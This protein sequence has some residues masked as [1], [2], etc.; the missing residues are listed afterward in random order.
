MTPPRAATWAMSERRR[1]PMACAVMAKAFHQQL[2]PE[3]EIDRVRHGRGAHPS[4][5]LVGGNPE[6]RNR[7]FHIDGTTERESASA[8]ANPHLSAHGVKQSLRV[9]T[10]AVLKHDCYILDLFDMRGRISLHEYEIRALTLRD[11]ADVAL[12]S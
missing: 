4:A 12:P 6:A 5:S 1:A 3:K 8:L 2:E 11:G 10:H 7:S 9:V